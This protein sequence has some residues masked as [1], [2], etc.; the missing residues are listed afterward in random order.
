MSLL[1][2]IVLICGFLANFVVLVPGYAAEV[3]PLVLD[4]T[5]QGRL[6]NVLKD[7][8]SQNKYL[9]LVEQHEI[10]NVGNFGKIVLYDRH[11]VYSLQDSGL[12]GVL[13]VGGFTSG[14]AT[15]STQSLSL[16]GLVPLLG[17]GGS[18]TRSE[19]LLSLPIGRF[20]VPFGF[21]SSIDIN[22]QF[23][24]KEFKTDYQGICSP[25]PG[26]KFAYQ[27]ENEVQFKT[28][29][30]FGRTGVGSAIVDV[31]C[32]VAANPVSATELSPSFKGEYLMVT[33]ESVAKA[34]QKGKV[35]YAFL[36]DLGLYL[37]L[38]ET[39][40]AQTIKVHYKSAEY[41]D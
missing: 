4:S 15:G 35:V 5:L 10:D 19:V 24:V 18:T 41:R 31:S 17:V 8:K 2:L 40:S 28:S 9:R 6:A 29:G 30:L 34:G 7:Y 39:G 12:W 23:R 20:F 3:D 11:V 38:S 16:C 14:A 22:R 27:I 36:R 26:D 33:C 13:S 25:I 1:R 37:M 32:L 21:R